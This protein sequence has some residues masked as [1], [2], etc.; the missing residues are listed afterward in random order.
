MMECSDVGDD[1]DHVWRSREGRF[2]LRVPAR[3]MAQLCRWC[4]QSGR[5]E[6]GGILVGHYSAALDCAVV[7]AVRSAP[8]DSRRGASWFARGTHGLQAWLDELWRAQQHYYLG[9][10]H[11]HP[12][13][14]PDPS[15]TDCA[16]MRRIAHD[17]SYRC[18]EPVLLIIGGDPR[19][20]WQAAASVFPAAAD[21]VQLGV[22]EGMLPFPERATETKPGSVLVADRA[23]VP[24]RLPSEE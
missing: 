13:A 17:P 3:T 18:P 4:R 11:F 24:E 5:R 16:Q 15:P 8:S 10:W 2:G 6:T 12:Y 9:E 14:A 23:S 21:A 20:A 7:S 19:G 1:G 22:C